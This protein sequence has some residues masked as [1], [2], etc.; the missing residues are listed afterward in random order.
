[1]WIGTLIAPSTFA[2]V[3]ER[4]AELVTIRASRGE[5]RPPAF[6]VGV[7]LTNLPAT[8]SFEVSTHHGREVFI[9]LLWIQLAHPIVVG[10]IL[11]EGWMM[12][13]VLLE[14]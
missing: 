6:A 2:S 14:H 9:V 4:V 11:L 3:L 13:N 12:F 10:E 7:L 1:V 5:C 8:I